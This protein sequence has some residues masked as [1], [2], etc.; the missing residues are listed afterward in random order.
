MIYILDTNLAKCA[1]MLDDK[2]LDKMIKNI[3][4]ILCNVHYRQSVDS[5]TYINIPL[6]PG[7]AEGWEFTCKWTKWGSECKANYEYLHKLGWQCLKEKVH[8]FGC[9]RE[10]ENYR[11]IVLWAQDNVPDLPL[12]KKLLSNSSH[13]PFPLVMPKKYQTFYK[14]AHEDFPNQNWHIVAFRDYY[15]EKLNRY[16]KGDL[17]ISTWTRQEI[18]YFIKEIL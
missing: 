13:T 15:K 16:R 2:S 6:K 18:P 9:D 14:N 7:K 3:A 12:Y 11:N 4:Q 5:E 17:K 1:Q 10:W 8:R